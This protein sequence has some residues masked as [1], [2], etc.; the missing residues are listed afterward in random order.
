MGWKRRRIQGLLAASFYEPLTPAEQ[1][2]LDSALAASDALRTQAD[3]LRNIVNAA[4]RISPQPDRDLLPAIHA[5][6]AQDVTAN[7]RSTSRA[8]RLVWASVCVGLLLVAGVVLYRVD[9]PIAPEARS[10]AGDSTRVS[11][12]LLAQAIQEADTLVAEHKSG[13]AYEILRK[14]LAAKPDD[15]LAAKVEL[16]VADLSFELK[17]YR[18]SLQAHDKLVTKYDQVLR[19]SPD[20][21][22][23]IVKRRDLLADAATNN[24]S[25]LYDLDVAMQDRGHEV[26]GLE[27]V[28]AENPESLVADLAADKMGEVLFD[29]SSAADNVKS[30]YLQAMEKAR[31][32]CTNAYAIALLDLK[33]GDI[34]RN[35]FKD[36]PAAEDHYRKAAQNPVFAK[37]AT[38]KLDSLAGIR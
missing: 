14:G 32:Q 23:T 15:P 36:Y 11:E 3:A 37:R 27:K 8:R 2:E 38:N 20:L 28:I 16:R 12:S 18:E 31:R 6:L 5:R 7:P 26:P 13:E 34:Y 25:S 24:F 17:R 35:D 9:H 22:R 21:Q 33:I 4:P 29:E 30:A 10:P 1:K 19:E